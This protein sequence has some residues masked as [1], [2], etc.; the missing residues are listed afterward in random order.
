MQLVVA[1]EIDTSIL[2]TAGRIMAAGSHETG[3]SV[4][5]FFK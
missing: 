1:R 3:L 4:V 2:A 5:R